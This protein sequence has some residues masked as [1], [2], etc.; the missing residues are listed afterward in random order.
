MKEMLSN[1]ILTGLPADDFA[2]LVPG[3]E[4]VSLSA[5][6]TLSE[7]CEPPRFV[8]FPEGS[9]VSFHAVMAD[10][11]SA[12][13][14]MV[15]K[16]G[17][18]GLPS[19]LGQH[20]PTHVLGVTTSGSALRMRAQSV[21]QEMARGEALRDSLIAYAGQYLAQVSQRAACNVLHRMEQRFAV[22]LLML[23]DRLGGEALDIT[24]ER[25]SQHL[26]VRRAG[27]S[28]VAGELQNRGIL[29]YARGSLRVIDR[30]A[31]EAVACE[32]YP[33]LCGVGRQPTRT[34]G[35]RASGMST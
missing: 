34:S 26:G 33:S 13:V 9:V 8:Y 2:R 11:K 4:P 29:A 3:L 19:L 31:L 7:P 27:V 18:A 28:V 21:E 15:G 5:G 30:A 23:T 14:G 6:E 35:L 22:W 1:R 20:S 25:I 17:F 32:C 10:G 24:Q 12:E 16:E